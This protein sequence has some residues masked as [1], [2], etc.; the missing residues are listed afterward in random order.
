M[1][2]TAFM[3]IGQIKQQTDALNR[4][5][6][7]QSEGTWDCSCGKKGLDSKFCP[8]CGNPRK[9]DQSANLRR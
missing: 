1:P 6:Q 7:P 5:A 3:G 4:S 9:S 8:E 2:M